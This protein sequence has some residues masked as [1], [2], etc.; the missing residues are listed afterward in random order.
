ME[1]FFDAAV[2]SGQL[3]CQ[4]HPTEDLYIYNYSRDSEYN[5]VWNEITLSARGLILDGAG[6]RRAACLRKFFNHGQPECEFDYN[7]PYTAYDKLDGYFGISYFVNDKIYL[8]SRGSFDSIYSKKANELLHEKYADLISRLNQGYTYIFEVIHSEIPIIIRYPENK[9]VLL[10]ILETSTGIE[11]DLAV[12][13]PGFPVCDEFP[14]LTVEEALKQDIYNREGYIFKNITSGKRM[15]VKF[16]NYIALH[17]LVVN[18]NRYDFIEFVFNEISLNTIL[19][20]NNIPDELFEDFR[21]KYDEIILARDLLNEYAA[22]ELKD[23]RLKNLTERQRFEYL[24]SKP[25]GYY[26]M[27]GYNN[28]KNLPFF[29]KMIKKVL[30]NDF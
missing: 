1:S 28:R 18:M 19:N 17:R 26:L 5:R 12:N 4:K 11:L 14:K 20:N 24:T 29:R 25:L 8:A 15:K 10:A 21:K 13:N 27:Y 23:P 3:V 2:S 6:N 9:L 30:N 16:P 7:E 22:H